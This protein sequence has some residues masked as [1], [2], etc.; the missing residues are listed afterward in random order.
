MVHTAHHL[1]LPRAQGLLLEP[2]TILE[3]EH[4]MS[5]DG[6]H[7]QLQQLLLLQQ[8]QINLMLQH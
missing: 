4:I 6:V 7:N 5:K 8:F 3:S 2:L 1:H